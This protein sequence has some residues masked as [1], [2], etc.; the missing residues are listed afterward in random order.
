M[1]RRP[2]YLIFLGYLMGS[3]STYIFSTYCNVT[4]DPKNLMF[5]ITFSSMLLFSF[6][7]FLFYTPFPKLIFE[8]VIDM[9]R[10]TDEIDKK[11]RQKWNP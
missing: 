5:F 7:V 8:L 4:Q 10:L 3:V 1:I 6:S 2:A 9:L 11:M